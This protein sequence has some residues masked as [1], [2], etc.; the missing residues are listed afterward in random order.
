[1]TGPKKEPE[2]ELQDRPLSLFRRLT[3]TG[4]PAVWPQQCSHLRD[5]ARQVNPRTPD[6]CEDHQP[7]DGWWVHLRVCVTCGRVGCCDSSKPQHATAHHL[8][9]G[10]PV[11]QSIEP[12]ERWRWCYLDEVLG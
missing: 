10:H 12:G 9:T 2:E 8:A 5:A 1:M 6:R 7:E 4:P 3:R 11:I